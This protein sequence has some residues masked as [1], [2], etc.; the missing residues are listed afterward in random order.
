MAQGA[1]VRG[2]ELVK[3]VLGGAAAGAMGTSVLSVVSG[4]DAVLRGRPSG[5]VPA[6]L[7]G[8]DTLLRAAALG[9]AS[10]ARSTAGV[11]ALALTSR[12]ADHGR[13]ASRLGSRTGRL[14]ASVAAAGELIADKLP[15]TPGRSGLP[16]LAPR[17]VLSGTAAAGLACREGDGPGLPVLVAV[18]TALATAFLGERLRGIVAG[19]FGSDLPGAVT[20]DVVAALLGFWG[21]RRR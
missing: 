5:D 15:A 13:I 21:A 18:G 7:V 16:G 12:P 19:R 20:E 8:A 11:A 2:K 4:I 1:G 14:G 17:V 3:G 9:A 6:R 10:G